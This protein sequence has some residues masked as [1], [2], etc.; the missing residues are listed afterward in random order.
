LTKKQ[1]ALALT[2]NSFIEGLRDAIKPGTSFQIT[3]D[4]FAPYKT[5]IPDTFGD[6]VDYDMLI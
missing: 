1:R 4:G 2:T 5:S 6:Y 3:T